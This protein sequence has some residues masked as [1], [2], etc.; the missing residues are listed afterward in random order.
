MPADTAYITQAEFEAYADWDTGTEADL[1]KVLQRAERDIDSMVG[2]WP[3]QDNGLKF[4]SPRTLNEADLSTAQKQA[5]M[6]ATAAQAEYRLKMGEEF[7]VMAQREEV[8]GPDFTTK[9]RLPYI[10]PKVTRELVPSG[11]LLR[12]ARARA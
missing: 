8:R 11:L 2:A 6:R 12:G 1:L 9:G 4:G 10:A 5:L 7:F 3:V